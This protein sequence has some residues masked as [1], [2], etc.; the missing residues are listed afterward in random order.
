MERN[1]RTLRTPARPGQGTAPVG[2]HET[3]IKFALGAAASGAR[4]GVG[5][6]ANNRRITI[7]IVLDRTPG[8][9]TDGV[10]DFATAHCPVPNARPPARSPLHRRSR[11]HAPLPRAG[12]HVEGDEVALRRPG[13]P[14]PAI[15]FARACVPARSTP[16]TQ[17][18]RSEER[19]ATPGTTRA[20]ARRDPRDGTEV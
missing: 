11:R 5:R 13:A 14:T 4:M 12:S 3:R 8:Q 15:R 2:G 17:P 7:P 18:L 20:A 19:R 10:P 1:D 9:L 6:T 16:R